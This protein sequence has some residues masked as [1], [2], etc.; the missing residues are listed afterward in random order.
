VHPSD[1]G[2][3]TSGRPNL[4]TP[5][6]HGDPNRPRVV[7]GLDRIAE[8][9]APMAGRTRFPWVLCGALLLA[10]GAGGM[11]WSGNESDKQ[12]IRVSTEPVPAENPVI[13]D[14]EF[15]EP[16]LADAPQPLIVREDPP[17]AVKRVDLQAAEAAPVPPPTSKTRALK[18]ATAKKSGTVSPPRTKA[19]LR[20]LPERLSQSDRD[21]ALLAA[22]VTR[23]K[24]GQAGPRILSVKWRQCA[25]A[26]SVA[27]ARQ[28]RVQL[29]GAGGSAEC[30]R[31]KREADKS[32][33]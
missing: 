26:A 20:A 15:Q 18:K 7:G 2:M 3:P 22:V 16:V 14:D 13:S 29:C 19:P 1:E 33:P 28:C 30:V 10:I 9:V 31:L 21:V 25:G 6:Q 32:R 8:A 4:N 23:T 27:E 12:I 11:L 24:A 17:P 5:S